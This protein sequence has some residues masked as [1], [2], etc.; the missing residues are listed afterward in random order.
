M[1]ALILAARI[2]LALLGLTGGFYAGRY[3][4][5]DIFRISS[6]PGTTHMTWATFL[7]L[8]FALVA[9]ALGLLLG[10]WLGRSVER[11]VRRMEVAVATLTL[12]EIGSGAV[13]I[14]GGLILAL[15]LLPPLSRLPFV[16]VVAP[17]LCSLLLGYLGG[18]IGIRKGVEIQ[19]ALRN[20]NRRSHEE[21]AT[22]LATEAAARAVPAQPAPGQAGAAVPLAAPAAGETNGG[23]LPAGGEQPKIVDTSAIIDGRIADVCA[24]GFLEGPLVIPEFVLDELRHIADSSDTL[25]RNRG[26]RGLDILNRIQKELNVPVQIWHGELTASEVDSKLVE[27]ARLLRAKVLTNDY[28]L[29]KVAVLHGVDVLNINDLAN[30]VKPAVLPGELLE[31]Y[32]L[33]DGKEA[34]Q[35]IGYLDDGTM[36]VVDGG[37]RFI[38]ETTSVEVTSVLQTSA[39]R[40]IFARPKATAVDSTAQAGA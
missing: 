35:G 1:K 11:L 37:K 36:V 25:K 23:Y 18:L 2:V 8:V 28:N 34:G 9:G 17:T 20:L 5:S 6:W 24:S 29:N 39:G 4:G 12:Q 32:V 15:L 16:G 7:G 3:V 14:F 27:L 21:R 38:G 30:A 10:P 22:R 13:G 31:I 40:M 19:Q 26:R 33:R